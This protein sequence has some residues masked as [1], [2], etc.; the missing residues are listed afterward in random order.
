MSE[1]ADLVSIVLSTHNGARYIRQSVE[2]CLA[3]SHRNIEL[4]IVDDASTDKTPEIIREFTDD[5]MK[6]LTQP[7][8]VGLANALN[9]GFSAASGDYLTWTS[10]DNYYS[11]DAIEKMLSV[12]QQNEDTDFVYANYHMIDKDGTVLRAGTTK[13]PA[14]LDIDNCVGACFL[15][16]RKV[17]QEVGTFNPDAFLAE[18]YEYWL[19]VR[20]KFRM[21]RMTEFLYYYRVHDASLTTQHTEKKVQEQVARVREPFISAWKRHYFRG[22]RCL[23]GGQEGAAARHLLKSVM[24]NPSYYETWR[25]LALLA[26]AVSPLVRIKSVDRFV[27]RR[28]AR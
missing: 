22:K 15:Y 4:V 7:E 10:D 25:L 12:L 19:R 5:R 17:Y 6:C 3:Q 16:R 24:L 9:I 2:S 8:S 28:R 18:D 14:E 26:L 27:Q 21:K 11:P 13:D 1:K 20:R 23:D